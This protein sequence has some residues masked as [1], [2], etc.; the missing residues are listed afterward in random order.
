MRNHAYPEA[1][2]GRS[3]RLPSGIIPTKGVLAAHRRRDIPFVPHVTVGR[4]DRL[5]ACEQI[6]KQLNEERRSVRTA[7]TRV[8]VVEVKEPVVRTVAE[9]PL[10]SRGNQPPNHIVPRPGDSDCSPSDR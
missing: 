10:V 2:P 3:S 9:I 8:A 7:I 5:A 6:A 1:A 4:H